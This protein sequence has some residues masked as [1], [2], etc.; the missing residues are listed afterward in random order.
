M[1]N[2]YFSNNFLRIV[3]VIEDIADQFD[4]HYL[5]SGLVLSLDYL[6]EG[7]LANEVKNLVL[8]FDLSPDLG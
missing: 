8:G 5:I 1:H 7:T 2:H 4:R 6:A 3:I